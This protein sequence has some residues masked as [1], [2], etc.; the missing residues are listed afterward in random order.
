M[1]YQVPVGHSLNQP[2]PLLIVPAAAPK[3]NA[4][5]PSRRDDFLTSRCKSP[6]FFS[7]KNASS[8]RQSDLADRAGPIRDEIPLPSQPPYTAFVGNLAFDLTES[9]LE[10]FF[11]N[12]KVGSDRSSLS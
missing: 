8:D 2:R 9:D 5:Y 7:D 3:E 12:T 11:Q 10:N 4:E 1:P 6:C